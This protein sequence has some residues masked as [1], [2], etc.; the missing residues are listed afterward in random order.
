MSEYLNNNININNFTYDIVNNLL[1]IYDKVMVLKI[2][3]DANDE[4]LRDEYI[5]AAMKH[6][7]RLINYQ[8]QIDAGFIYL[9]QEMNMKNLTTLVYH[10]VF[11]DR[12]GQ[13]VIAV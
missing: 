8:T 1:N 12:I 11:L 10:F 13:I 3:V 7:L 5:D 2:Y 9:P 6:N 4:G